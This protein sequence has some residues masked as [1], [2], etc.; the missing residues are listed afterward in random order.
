MGTV[1]ENVDIDLMGGVSSDVVATGTVG[2]TSG[3][4]FG[5]VEINWFGSTGGVTTPALSIVGT[6]VPGVIGG[7]IDLDWIAPC[8]K[9]IGI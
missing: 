4:Y 5:G 7:C 2:P 1:A 3:N 6:V 8:Y 9:D